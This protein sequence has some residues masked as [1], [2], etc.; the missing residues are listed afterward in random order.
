[1]TR[2]EHIETLSNIIAAY[3]TPVEKYLEV[4][5]YIHSPAQESAITLELLLDCRKE[6]FELSLTQI[7][8]FEHL[9][10]PT[11]GSEKEVINRRIKVDSEN[12]YTILKAILPSYPNKYVH[13]GSLNPYS[14]K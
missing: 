3:A 12:I 14:G 6:Y 1:M 7:I 8:H 2:E 13:T 10:D 11:L 4:F 9:G 5:K